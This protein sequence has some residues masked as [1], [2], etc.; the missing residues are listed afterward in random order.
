VWD[1]L[2]GTLHIPSAE[3][4]VLEFGVEPDR[5]NA[6]T[7][8]GELIAP[9]GRAALQFKQLIERRSQPVPLAAPRQKRA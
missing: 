2:F 4:E 6:H 5:P 1:W 3:P 7:I 9:F 8:K